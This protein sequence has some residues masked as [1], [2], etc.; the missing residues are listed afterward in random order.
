MQAARKERLL[1]F[2]GVPHYQAM[3]ENKWLNA[4]ASGF[5]KTRLRF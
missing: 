4:L 5:T 3:A 2:N 1:P